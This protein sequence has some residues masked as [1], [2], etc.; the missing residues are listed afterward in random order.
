[1]SWNFLTIIPRCA[2]NS[3]AT[4]PDQVVI[5]ILVD[6]SPEMVNVSPPRPPPCKISVACSLPWA[7]AVSHCE[8]LAQLS[9]FPSLSQ[10]LRAR[11][12]K[13]EA[14]WRRFLSQSG[15]SN[16]VSS[17]PYLNYFTQFN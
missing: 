1:M 3:E 7:A 6:L 14:R 10:G 16:G 9:P 15:P 8:A 5:C 13:K 12:K 4:V 2:K 17:Q 11:G